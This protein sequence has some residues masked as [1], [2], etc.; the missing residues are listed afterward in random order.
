[1]ISGSINFNW[2]LTVQNE[3]SLNTRIT[4]VMLHFDYATIYLIWNYIL[5]YKNTFFLCIC[6]TKNLYSCVDSLHSM[7]ECRLQV[8]YDNPKKSLVFII[9]MY[10][11]SSVM[12]GMGWQYNS[13]RE[14]TTDKFTICYDFTFFSI[15]VQHQLYDT[16]TLQRLAYTNYN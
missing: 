11:H 6:I 9:C 2:I 3:W 15:L 4:Y 5:V 16:I 1:M 7:I 8:L 12:N 10:T 14:I 13:S